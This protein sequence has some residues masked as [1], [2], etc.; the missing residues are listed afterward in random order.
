MTTQRQFLTK[1]YGA[2]YN[3]PLPDEDALDLTHV[4]KGSAGGEYLRRFWQ[5]VAMSSE[6]SKLPIKVRMFGEDLVL[7][8][9][10]AGDCGLLDQHCSHRGTS[11]EFGLP[12]D[13]GIRCCY[14]GWLFGTDGRILETPGDPPGSTLKDRLCHGAY[15]VKEYRGLSSDTSARRTGCPNFRSTTATSIPTTSSCPTA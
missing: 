7:F 8:R 10:T 4:E 15:P 6:V 11:L 13:R 3:Q 14:H 5:P 9:T 12:T 2:Y 1:P